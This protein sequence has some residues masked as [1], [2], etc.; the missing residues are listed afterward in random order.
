M[1]GKVRSS[2]GEVPRLPPLQIPPCYYLATWNFLA[3]LCHIHNTRLSIF[4]QTV[5]SYCD[6][7][8]CNGH[9]F[10]KLL[11][12]KYHRREIFFF[13]RVWACSAPCDILL[14]VRRIEIHL[15]T[16]FLTYLLTLRWMGVSFVHT[17][18]SVCL[19]ASDIWLMSTKVRI[20]SG[21]LGRS[22]PAGC[23]LWA[24]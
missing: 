10:G 11:G 19:F 13:F 5:L 24:Q 22:M 4:C 14:K 1:G 23:I 18:F 3:D 15:L 8:D 9:S 16:Y 21:W 17:C 6:E 20:Y 2:E 12:S 7:F